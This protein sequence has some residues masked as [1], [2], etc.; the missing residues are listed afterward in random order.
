MAEDRAT[1]LSKP[2]TQPTSFLVFGHKSEA[3]YEPNED[4]LEELERLDMTMLGNRTTNESWF[5]KVLRGD[6]SSKEM[7]AIRRILNVEC[8]MQ[9]FPLETYHVDFLQKTS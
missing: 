7:T 2:K 5:G 9:G 3:G 1:I 8:N 4:E 6:E